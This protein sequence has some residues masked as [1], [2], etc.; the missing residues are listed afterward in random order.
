MVSSM[1]PYGFPSEYYH[2]LLDEQPYYLAP[3]RLYGPDIAGPLV[4]NPQCWFSWHGPLP[5]DKSIR[6][7]ATEYLFPS[8]W[9][10]WVDDPGTRAI[11]PYCIGREYA[12]YLSDLSPGS[13]LEKEL[14][15][16]VR[17]VLTRAN[18]LV[19]PDFDERRHREWLDTVWHC[20]RNFERGYTAL[21]GLIPP[22][23]LGAMRR[24]YRYHTRVGSFTLGDGQV[25]RRHVA[26]NEG[27]A[28]YIHCQ[29]THAV[30]DI[31]GNL[32][33]PSYSYLAAYESGSMLE[34]HTDREQCEFSIT[35]CIDA[36]PEPQAQVP[37]PI[38]L[39]IPDGTLRVWQHLGDGLL[40]RGRYLPHYRDMLPEGYTSTSLLLHYVDYSFSA[41]LS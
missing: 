2:C 15:P 13:F 16:H 22:F 24:Y 27:V 29:L 7:V 28:R 10:V 1:T 5:P 36:T 39:D 8:E 12:G 4:V 23:H 3:S 30:S 25:A 31:V 20:A 41:T 35:L 32:V 17:W 14:P 40:F 11:W 9:M 18:I 6:T 26:H 37:W 34:R 38:Q 33:K 21:A 19:E